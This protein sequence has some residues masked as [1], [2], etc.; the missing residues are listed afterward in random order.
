MKGKRDRDA[1]F[2]FSFLADSL[3][4]KPRAVERRGE[5]GVSD[6]LDFDHL[7]EVRRTHERTMPEAAKKDKVSPRFNPVFFDTIDIRYCSVR[8][9]VTERSRRMLR[10]KPR[11]HRKRYLHRPVTMTYPLIVHLFSTC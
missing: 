6:W 5:T 2:T 11:L 9:R 8:R 1:I 7:F 3:S 10:R 4:V